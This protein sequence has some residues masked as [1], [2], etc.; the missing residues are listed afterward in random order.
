MHSSW[1][2]FVL[3]APPA[4]PRW[5]ENEFHLDAHLHKERIF[6]NGYPIGVIVVMPYRSDIHGFIY[7]KLIN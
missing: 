1:K 3:I 6:I 7:I 5:N 2:L 4:S